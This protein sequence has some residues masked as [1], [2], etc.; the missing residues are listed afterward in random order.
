M[1]RDFVNDTWEQFN[2]EAK[3]KQ[4]ILFGAGGKAKDI[5]SELKKSYKITAIVDNDEL[6][7]GK[8]IDGIPIKSPDIVHQEEII[9]LI[10]NSFIGVIAK[11]LEDMGFRGM[12]FSYFWLNMENR[13]VRLQKD[14]DEKAI[15]TLYNILQDETSKDILTSIIEKRKMGFLDY[16]DIRTPTEYFLTDIFPFTKEEVYVDGGVFDGDSI[17]KF[18]EIMNYSYKKIYGFEADTYNYKMAVKNL[19]G[20]DGKIELYNKALWNKN[21]IGSFVVG[22]RESS[23]VS[24]TLEEMKNSVKVEFCRLDDMIGSE[25]VTFLKMDI[26]GTELEALEGAKQIL[27][28]DKPK[29]AI[30][31]YH[32]LDDLWK[33]PLYIH[34]LVPEYKLYI[35]HHSYHYC[36]TVL[37]A[38]YE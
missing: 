32:K 7:W 34:E 22:E 10:I 18:I 5:V 14:F 36:D 23:K 26:E 8:E 21:E 6:K 20:L 33:I 31:I 25:K 9:V 3:G 29:L 28:Q 24:E 1:Y 11:Q 35:R 30:C 17:L 19:S 4:L 15:K 37:Y 2:I 27:K 13:S 38:V 12:Y 16:T